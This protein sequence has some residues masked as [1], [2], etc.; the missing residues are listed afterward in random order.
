MDHSVEDTNP[1]SL[2]MYDGLTNFRRWRAW[3]ARSKKIDSN[4]HR[5]IRESMKS[6]G[7]SE[8]ENFQVRMGEIRFETDEDFAIAQVS[9]FLNV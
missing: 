2:Q 7:M 5:A 1:K 8:P 6:M 9:G 3:R 4:R